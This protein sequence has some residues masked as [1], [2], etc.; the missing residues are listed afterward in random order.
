MIGGG[1]R[2]CVL[3]GAGW[4]SLVPFIDRDRLVPVFD[5]VSSK[6]PIT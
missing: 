5:D 2:G 6:S 1:G 3:E 4:G